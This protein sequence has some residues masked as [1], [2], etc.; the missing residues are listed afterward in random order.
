[1]MMVTQEGVARTTQQPGSP[2]KTATLCRIQV[3][4]YQGDLLNHG[5]LWITSRVLHV[6]F[7]LKFSH[8]SKS[9]FVHG[10]A[11]PWCSDRL[12]WRYRG[13]FPRPGYPFLLFEHLQQNKKN[14]WLVPNFQDCLQNITLSV[15]SAVFGASSS[16]SYSFKYLFLKNCMACLF[17]PFSTLCITLIQ[18]RLKLTF[19]SS[20]RVLT[21]LVAIM[22]QV[23]HDLEFYMKLN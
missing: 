10:S 19:N 22:N 21:S 5:S 4:T 12:L 6:V 13:T 20:G 23:L 16:T 2:M 1:M 3:P 14:Q 18:Q 7:R 9:Q 17:I 8:F 15:V 11:F